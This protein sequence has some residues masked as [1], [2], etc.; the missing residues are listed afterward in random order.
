MQWLIENPK[1]INSGLYVG[2][3]SYAGMVVPAAVED[4]LQGNEIKLQPKL[5][6]K[7]YVLGNPI[8][9]YDKCESLRYKFANDMSFLP[10]KLYKTA[11]I[12]CNDDF[13]NFD[14][15]N[16]KC[17]N[18][19][20][21]MK[22]D[23]SSIGESHILEHKCLSISLKSNKKQNYLYTKSMLA[24]AEFCRVQHYPFIFSWADDELVKKALHTQE[25]TIGHWFLCN[26][27]LPYEHDVKDTFDYHLNNS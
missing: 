9:E 1:F 3:D 5:N 17:S 13:K 15:K 16:T 14:A 4:I 12:S 21:T 20:Q 27:S 22:Q 24:N 8:S 26:R 23:I 25:G 10:D 18:Y 11:E 7:G 2:G 19:V 6:L